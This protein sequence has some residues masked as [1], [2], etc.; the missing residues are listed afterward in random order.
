M[1]PAMIDARLLPLQRTLMQPPA[2]WLVARGVRADQITLAGCV[3]GLLAT[4]AAAYQLYPLALLGLALN[5]LADLGVYAEQI[6][7][8]PTDAFDETVMRVEIAILSNEE[9]WT[10]CVNRIC[11]PRPI[12]PAR[13]FF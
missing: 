10:E 1:T 2:R 13:R 9:T 12:V 3:I 11:K 5:R 8:P 4:L 6:V 7:D